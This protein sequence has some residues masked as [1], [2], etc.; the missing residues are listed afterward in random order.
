MSERARPY[1]FFWHVGNGWV[2]GEFYLKWTSTP[3]PPPKR[4]PIPV[5]YWPG[6]LSFADADSVHSP[7]GT[8]SS[9]L[10]AALQGQDLS[11]EAANEEGAE[12]MVLPAVDDFEDGDAEDQRALWATVKRCLAANPIRP[13]RDLDALLSLAVGVNM[14]FPPASNLGAAILLLQAGAAFG[15]EELFC[16]AEEGVEMTGLLL[17]AGGAAHVNGTGQRGW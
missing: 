16:A 14:G 13:Q 10:A 11:E 5:A 17:L 2:R 4:L 8:M 3:S 9:D 7:Q 12:A 6:W 1:F 15:P